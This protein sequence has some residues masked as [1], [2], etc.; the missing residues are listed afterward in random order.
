M[1]GA[2]AQ[3]LGPLRAPG[4]GP[5]RG[6]ARLVPGGQA[7]ADLAPVPGLQRRHPVDHRLGG[8]LPLQPRLVGA[9]QPP[10]LA[11]QRHERLDVAGERDGVPEQVVHRDPAAVGEVLHPGEALL[12]RR[13]DG[14]V[15]LAPEELGHRGLPEQ[16][17]T[18]RE[19]LHVGEEVGHGAL[20]RHRQDGARSRGDP[21]E[22]PRLP[23][24]LGAR[25]ARAGERDHH[26]AHRGREPLEREVGEQPGRG[27]RVRLERL[28]APQAERGRRLLR[29]PGPQ[30]PH[31][32]VEHRP[33][34][35]GGQHPRG[36]LGPGREVGASRL[37]GQGRLERARRREQ[38]PQLR[39]GG[40][41]AGRLDRGHQ[42][43]ER[44]PDAP[45]RHRALRTPRRSPRR[46]RAPRPRPRLPR[47]G[48]PR[49]PGGPRSPRPGERRPGAPG[50]RGWSRRRGGPPAR[51]PACRD[52]PP[53]RGGA[54]AGRRRAAPR[55]GRTGPRRSWP[56]SRVRSAPRCGASGRAV[57][58]A[59]RPA[60]PGR[61]PP[62]LRT[63]RA[64]RAAACPPWR[65]R[66]PS[67]R[68][69]CGARRSRGR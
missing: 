19:V 60:V 31:Q 57:R 38:R 54:A 62:A 58:R 3:R 12:R 50:R 49:S 10:D 29:L 15:E 61:P 51:R 64:P 53:P 44:L 16:A 37:A 9:E 65:A 45:G 67:R 4:S 28:L 14:Q 59:G 33:R 26:P 34:A 66:R 18:P 39:A 11:G 17:R 5:F 25:L 22:T 23:L 20:L 68:R 24:R 27:E 69:R 7:A 35:L 6:R 63:G 55:P 47:P 8:D 1:Q 2:P 36:L 13:Q 43:R 42:L 30:R 40:R 46:R 21:V 32:H 52:S 41:L 56:R 48:R